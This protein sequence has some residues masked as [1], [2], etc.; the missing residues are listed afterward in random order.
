LPDTIDRDHEP[1]PSELPFTRVSGRIIHDF[2]RDFSDSAEER[3]ALRVDFIDEQDHLSRFIAGIQEDLTGS[4]NP[5]DADQFIDA[6]AMVWHLI[7]LQRAKDTGHPLKVGGYDDERVLA[8]HKK[9]G[10]RTDPDEVA[11]ET[12]VAIETDVRAGEEVRLETF[13]SKFEHDQQPLATLMRMV[14]ARHSGGDSN[15]QHQLYLTAALTAH[16]VREQ[17]QIGELHDRTETYSDVG[18]DITPPEYPAPVSNN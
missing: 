13:E 4:D 1:T 17:Q 6:A 9:R 2:L 5:E 14:T 10:L 8:E 11:D 15:R 16:C 12:I 3:H 7:K 18:P